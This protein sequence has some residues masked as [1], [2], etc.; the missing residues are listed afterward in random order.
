MSYDYRDIPAKPLSEIDLTSGERLS[1][2]VVITPL[3]AER[4]LQNNGRNRRLNKNTMRRYALMMGRGEWDWC[5]GDGPLKFGSNGEL[6]NGQHR[7]EAQVMANV[8]GAYD[9]R[10][11]VPEESYQVMDS[12]VARRSAD[13]FYGREQSLNVS[14][15]A[16]RILYA[17]YG[18]TEPSASMKST[19]DR[20][21]PTRVE[22]IEFAESHY[23]ELR[24]YVRYGRRLKDQH[25]RGSN[26]A[27]S[28]AL[29]IGG[30]GKDEVESFI[31]AY[32]E[33]SDNTG[34]TKETVLKKLVDRN[35]KPRP[36]WYGGVTLMAYD[37]WVQGRGVKL[38]RAPD[39]TKRYKAAVADFSSRWEVD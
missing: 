34:I 35:F 5:D 17:R 30:F 1:T 14:A 36:H 16:K 2:T 3:D 26:A 21:L 32:V 33:G 27:Y 10:T 9:I 38:L 31:A 24:E 37:A 19:G 23:D 20:G 13:Y 39:V 11:G 7:L 25:T 29:Y 12:G 6:R 15:L 8:T 4:L 22:E 28:C 18:Y